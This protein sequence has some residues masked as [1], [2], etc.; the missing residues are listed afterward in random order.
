[1]ILV[2]ETE[3][4]AKGSNSPVLL[5]VDVVD[6]QAPGH[7]HVSFESFSASFQD[8]VKIGFWF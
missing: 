8:Q 1:M 3:E 7:D 5:G 2:G 6:F 4:D